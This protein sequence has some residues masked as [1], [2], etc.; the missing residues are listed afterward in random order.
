MTIWHT[1][2]CRL[3]VVF[4]HG[5]LIDIKCKSEVAFVTK[6]EREAANAVDHS[7]I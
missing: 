4:F 5:G 6:H 2:A 1:P 3:I 7:S